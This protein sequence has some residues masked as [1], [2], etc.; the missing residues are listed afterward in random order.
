MSPPLDICHKPLNIYIF[1]PFWGPN[2][3]FASKQSKR[4]IS[5]GFFPRTP[6]LREDLQRQFVAVLCSRTNTNHL[7]LLQNI[8][9]IE[10]IIH[11]YEKGIK[12]GTRPS[13]YTPPHADN[14]L[15]SWLKIVEKF[16][17]NHKRKIAAVMMTSRFRNNAY[18]LHT[19]THTHIYLCVYLCKLLSFP[20]NVRKGILFTS[21]PFSAGIK[22]NYLWVLWIT[23][24]ILF[25]GSKIIWNS[26]I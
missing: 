9:G 20:L 10:W 3:M 18:F 17:P 7:S 15:R 8:F 11:F 25:G 26:P 14:R 12:V 19:H 2:K 16:S 13:P 1:A 4:V 23:Y 5:N 6:C 22:F 21:N 24:R